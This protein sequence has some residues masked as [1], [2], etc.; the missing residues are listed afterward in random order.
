MV[1]SDAGL[2]GDLA[3]LSESSPEA[4][5]AKPGQFFDDRILRQVNA[6]K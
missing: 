1:T 3:F 2:H 4:T 5:S 6:T